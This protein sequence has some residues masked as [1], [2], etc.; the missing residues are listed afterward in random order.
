[1]SAGILV[2]SFPSQAAFQASPLYT[3]LTALK[4]GLA[5]NSASGVMGIHQGT[6]LVPT[7]SA[8]AP[9]NNQITAEVQ[10]AAL[11]EP[12][13]MAGAADSAS[14]HKQFVSLG[15]DVS[16]L[17]P[18]LDLVLPP[19]V[20]DTLGG[21]MGYD[22]AVFDIGEDLVS[23]TGR[24][25]SER[26]TFSVE[27]QS[28]GTF[29][30]IGT[31]TNSGGDYINVILLDVSGIPGIPATVDEIHI[32]DAVGTIL[33]VDQCLDVEAVVRLHDGVTTPARAMSWGAL[34]ASRR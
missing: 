8:G 16:G 32:V 19:V 24:K 4:A 30:T 21:F 31:M 6:E 23:D 1:M 10:A 13:V 5:A 22:I 26:T 17:G 2:Q 25:N 20:A 11:I 12:T 29:Y 28:E 15:T 9:A 3:Y 34:K 14:Y 7:S 33:P 27:L 18:S